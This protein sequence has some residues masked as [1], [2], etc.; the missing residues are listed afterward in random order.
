MSI[1]LVAAT[2]THGGYEVTPG[3]TLYSPGCAEKLVESAGQQLEKLFR[4]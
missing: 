4:P 3:A 1:V 2:H